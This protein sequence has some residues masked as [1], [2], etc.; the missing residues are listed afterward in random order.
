[1][2]NLPA[3]FNELMAT[4]PIYREAKPAAA[5]PARPPI[6]PIPAFRN[7]E[8]D[9]WPTFPPFSA[10][11]NAPLVNPLAAPTIIAAAN[12]LPIPAVATAATGYKYKRAT[13]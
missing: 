2:A 10:V 11:P 13:I 5:P 1:M 9:T 7:P 12:G 4:L 6:A 8:P 3:T